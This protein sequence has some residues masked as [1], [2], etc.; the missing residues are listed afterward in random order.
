M[1]PITL[2]MAIPCFNEENA[3]PSM[4]VLLRQKFL[5]LIESGKIS[6][7]SRILFVDDGS[8]DRTWEVITSLAK[9][10]HL[11]TGVKL[12]MNVGQQKALLAGLMEARG[13]ADAV[14]SMDADGQ[15]DIDAIDAMLEKYAE[16]ADIVYGVRSK[17]ETDTFFKRFTAECFYSL[18]KRMGARLVTNHAD[19]RL[20][21][22]RALDA[23][24]EFGESN[25]FLRG[26]IPLL[27][28][29]SAIVYY[30]RKERVAGDSHYPLS[31]MAM[32]AIDGITSLS[33][34]PIRL[35]SLLGVTIAAMSFLGILLSVI[36]S[37]R[38][39]T[40]PGWA[41][42]ISVMFLIGGIEMLSIGIIGEYIGKIY[43]ET[44]ARPRYIIE[45]RLPEKG[46]CE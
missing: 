7:E 36:L 15:D 16:G 40:I 39:A 45:V 21:S 34:S 42:M 32:L 14:I 6:G 23:L 12:A 44:K 10:S 2:Y 38:G 30:E 11:F 4:G 13:K 24:S 33:V 41:S 35:I 3:L 43:V 26:L 29:T 17:R 8:M 37:I 5:S 31:K 20:L 28:F 22:K 46:E 19:Y 18:M 9:S 27:G 25:I 1:K